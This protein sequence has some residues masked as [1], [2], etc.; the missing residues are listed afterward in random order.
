M[1]KPR[2][3]PMKGREFERYCLGQLDKCLTS[4]DQDGLLLELRGCS[5]INSFMFYYTPFDALYFGKD[6]RGKPKVL[7]ME[8]KETMYPAYYMTMLT[9][10]GHKNKY[11]GKKN[12]QRT[13]AKDKM[14]LMLEL[15]FTVGYVI[16]FKEPWS[17]HPVPGPIE[18]RI[19]FI[20][21]DLLM[22]KKK[23]TMHDGE[24]FDLFLENFINV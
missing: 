20:P 18:P 23:V 5:S 11:L 7:V 21:Y 4:H 16:H 12:V 13:L 3:E 6:K 9:N 2:R 22:S 10:G 19:R 17:K 24:Q 1:T 8:F 14:R 15:G